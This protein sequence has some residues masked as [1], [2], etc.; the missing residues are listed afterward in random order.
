LIAAA[1]R[2]ELRITLP[3][4]MYVETAVWPW[5]SRSSRNAAIG[6]LFRP[7][8]LIPRRSTT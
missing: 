4:A 3:L 6:T 7:P 2:S 5:D 1:D 8:T